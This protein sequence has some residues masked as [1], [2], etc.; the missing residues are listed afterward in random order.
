MGVMSTDID[1]LPGP[2]PD[3]EQYEQY[4]QYEQSDQQHEQSN[5]QYDQSYE[6]RHDQVYEQRQ[7]NI[8]SNI[9]KKLESVETFQQDENIFSKEFTMEYLL[10]LIVIFLS[11]MPVSDEYTRK[12]VVML[13]FNLIRSS[14][15]VNVV[16]CLL[17]LIIFI[18]VKNYILPR[19]T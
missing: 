11:T 3:E 19:I 16:K 18:I 13:P 8:S 15:M 5:Q 7:S 9:Q 14:M 2:I 4:E 1:D 12:F 10:I 6:K 17:L